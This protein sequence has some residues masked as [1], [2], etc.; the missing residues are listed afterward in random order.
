MQGPL[1]LPGA[2]EEAEFAAALA[3]RFHPSFV[4]VTRCDVEA[5]RK[6]REE[7]ILD[8]TFSSALTCFCLHFG[9]LPLPAV[10]SI[11]FSYVFILTDKAKGLFGQMFHVKDGGED[12]WAGSLQGEVR[13]E[14]GEDREIAEFTQPG[15]LKQNSIKVVSEEG[16]KARWTIKSIK[17]RNRTAIKN[18]ISTLQSRTKQQHSHR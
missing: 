7:F 11:Q 5:L 6:E 1:Y 9:L 18:T 10:R 12:W 17:K 16:Q 13:M 15:S 4:Q 8:W 2:E 14:K 3:G